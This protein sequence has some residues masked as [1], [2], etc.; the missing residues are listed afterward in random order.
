MFEVV[1]TT[2]KQGAMSGGDRVHCFFD[3]AIDGKVVGRII[4]EVGRRV[5]PF[6]ADGFFGAAV[7]GCDAADV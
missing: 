2:C 1:L 6:A 3:I 4:F 7:H 5:C